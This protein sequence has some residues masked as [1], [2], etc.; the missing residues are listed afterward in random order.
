VDSEVIAARRK[1]DD[2]LKCG[3]SGH[4]WN[5]CWAKEPNRS[6]GNTAKRRGDNDSRRSSSFKKPKTSAAAA[7]VAS[8][9]GRIIE[10]PED[11]DEDIDIW[12]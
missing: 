11:E 7:A 2:C 6:A 3:K 12:T 10:I 1:T 4:S 9:P 8:E 5:D